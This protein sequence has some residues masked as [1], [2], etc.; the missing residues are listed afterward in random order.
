MIARSSV[1]QD[2]KKTTTTF[3]FLFPW[4]KVVIQVWNYMRM[5]CDGIFI[6]GW[7]FPLH[8]LFHVIHLACLN[9]KKSTKAWIIFFFW[10]T[11]G[12]RFHTKSQTK[13]KHTN[14]VYKRLEYAPVL[15]MLL[16]FSH[17]VLEI[18][19]KVL[20]WD[21][22][23]CTHSV[24]LL[25]FS[26]TDQYIQHKGQLWVSGFHLSYKRFSE[27]RQRNFG[28]ILYISHNFVCKCKM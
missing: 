27:K 12:Q 13:C 3:L 9:A 10:G 2:L 8:F 4:K 23:T 25:W 17:N 6:F 14:H 22:N 18:T 5:S 15:E 16:A 7:T 19:K 28:V 11:V 26:N 1:K 24:V 21:R 20:Q